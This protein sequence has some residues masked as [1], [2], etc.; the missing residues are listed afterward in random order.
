[1]P[2]AGTRARVQGCH[3]HGYEVGPTGGSRTPISI[4]HKGRRQ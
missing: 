1:M 4:F 2:L 3:L